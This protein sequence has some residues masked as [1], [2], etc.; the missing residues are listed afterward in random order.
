MA[1]KTNS[2]EHHIKNNRFSKW[3]QATLQFSP[4]HFTQG[5]AVSSDCHPYGIIKIV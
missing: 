3:L 5:L 4:H 2:Y 1:S